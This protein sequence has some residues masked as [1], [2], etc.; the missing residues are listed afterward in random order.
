MNKEVKTTDMSY[1]AL[2]EE[3][4]NFQ[5]FRREVQVFSKMS[6]SGI[7]NVVVHYECPELVRLVLER[8]YPLEKLYRKRLDI[9]AAYLTNPVQSIASLLFGS[10][11]PDGVW[12][13]NMECP[14][15]E[16]GFCHRKGVLTGSCKDKTL[17]ISG[18]DSPDF[19]DENGAILRSALWI[20]N[21][22]RNPRLKRGCHLVLVTN[23]KVIFP[24]SVARVY[25]PL[26]DEFE[27][28]HIINSFILLFKNANYSIEIKSNIE[29]H[30]ALREIVS[31]L[32]GKTYAEAA[33]IFST[34]ILNASYP[35][36]SKK[37]DTVLLLSHVHKLSF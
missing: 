25:F 29:G 6:I 13:S 7:T 22:F 5:H 33:H 21:K 17:V 12:G 30:E 36:D 32:K 1:A 34:A 11:V 10:P 3:S 26:V 16:D 8:A 14:R 19:C 2:A 18:I 24:F 37:I 4:V 20:F 28:N 15:E 23:E 35:R 27:A 31:C 9:N